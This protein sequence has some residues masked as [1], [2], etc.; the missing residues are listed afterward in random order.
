MT[1]EQLLELLERFF[2]PVNSGKNALLAS[3]D[4]QDIESIKAN[5]H[6]IK[7]SSSF[8]GMQSIYDACQHIS[9]TLQSNASPDFIELA[10]HFEKAWVG[11][12][13]EVEAYIKEQM[14]A[15]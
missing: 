13:Q 8:L 1:K 4:N 15:K 9:E 12:R 2:D 3:F 7:G 5:A 14:P 11:S 6:F 10:N